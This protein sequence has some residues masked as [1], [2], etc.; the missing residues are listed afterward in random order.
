[1]KDDD[2]STKETL[3]AYI[4]SLAQRQG[5]EHGDWGEHTGSSRKGETEIKLQA[6]LLS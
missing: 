5:H 3:L 1:M 4:P 6:I 2:C